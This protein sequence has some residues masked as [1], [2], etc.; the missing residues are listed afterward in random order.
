M[1]SWS[2]ELHFSPFYLL[3]RNLV[4]QS[5]LDVGASQIINDILIETHIKVHNTE[6]N[7]KKFFFVFF[8]NAENYY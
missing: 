3:P 1:L 5:F 2:P 4:C 6:I 8:S 7:T